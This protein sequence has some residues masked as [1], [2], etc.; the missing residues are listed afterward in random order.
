MNRVKTGNDQLDEILSGGIPRNSINLVTGL[1][2]TGKTILAESIIFSNASEE[3]KAL[4][5]STVSEP[6]DKIIRY[7]QGFDFFDPALIGD[8]IVYEDLSEIL[9]TK[10]L[11]G[12]IDRIIDLIKETSPSYLVID[13]FKALHDFSTSREDFRRYLS[14]LAGVLTSLAVT[15]F[16]VGEYDSQDIHGLP[17]FAIADGIYELVLKKIG[18]RDA[19]FIRVI[20]M[21][22]SGFYSGEHA[23]KISNKGLEIFPRLKTPSA[24][25]EYVVAENRVQTG[26]EVLDKMISEG[27]WRGSSS[28]VFGPPGSGKSLLALH[29][30]FKGIEAGEKGLIATMEE[31]PTQLARIVSGFGWDLQE[32]ID[33]G[34][35][36]LLYVSPVEIYID[37]FIQK[38][39]QR[40]KETGAKRLMIDSLNNLQFASV[41]EIRFREYMYSLVQT[42]AVEGITTFMTNEIQN[43]F[44]TTYLTQYGISHM[45]DNVILL[46][47]IRE[48]SMVKRAVTVLKTRGSQHDHSI[49]QFNISSKGL[50]VGEAFEEE[51]IFGANVT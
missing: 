48:K 34:M 1:P 4:Y 8:A 49:R 33:S 46:H 19:R 6:L 32:M 40:L 44:A 15:S 42:L 13:S 41:D 51:T 21:R 25:P 24:P 23:Y 37:E 9:R 5:I 50:S 17:E 38:I 7:L 3:N 29:F 36:E 47:Y 14:E 12:A 30:I 39:M 18:I 27:V 22:G 31:N 20:K 28:V 26:V 2:G 16:W 35:L 43:L 11:E 45:S 10:G